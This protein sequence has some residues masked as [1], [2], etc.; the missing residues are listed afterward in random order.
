MW[1]GPG[2]LVGV[3]FLTGLQVDDARVSP[4]YTDPAAFVGTIVG[5][6]IASA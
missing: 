2:A 4:R 5:R 6:H 1:T 3:L